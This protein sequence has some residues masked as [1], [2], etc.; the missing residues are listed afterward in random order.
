MNSK[1]TYTGRLLLLIFWGVYAF[2]ACTS[3]LYVGPR[4]VD[5]TGAGQQKCLLVRSKP[6]GNWILHYQSIK[7]L[8]YEP[9]FSYQIKVKRER[10]AHPPADGST[11]RYVMV[12]LM[13]KKDVADDLV[14]DDLTGKTWVLKD[15]V[16]NRQAYGVEDHAPQLIFDDNGKVHGSGGCNKFFSTYSV[17]HRTITFGVVGATRMLC[18]DQME[19]E[20]A[21]F[22][23]LAM[24]LRAFFDDDE[25]ILSADGGNKMILGYK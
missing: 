16:K 15:L 18:D 21:F 14:V 19:L 5:C 13:D 20:K 2:S 23:L 12:E 3:E 9:G 8:D 1:I 22:A 11:F 10:I 6:E 24:D 4:Q 7:G 25:L 17:D